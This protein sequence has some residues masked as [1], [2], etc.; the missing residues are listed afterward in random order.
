[1]E[2]RR[3]WNAAVLAGI[4]VATNTDDVRAGPRRRHEHECTS[5]HK[6]IPPGKQGRRCAECRKK[7]SSLTSG[8]TT[9]LPSS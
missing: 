2:D 9:D 6:E 3:R 8:A 7:P 1:M 4:L 5:C